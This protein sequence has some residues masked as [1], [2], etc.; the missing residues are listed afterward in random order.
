MADTKPKRHR[1][2]NALLILVLLLVALA[3]SL[4]WRPEMATTALERASM[5]AAGIHSEYTQLG[6]YRIHYLVAGEG[7]PLVLVHGLGGR[8]EEWAPLMHGLAKQHFRVYAIDL[9]GYGRSDKPDVDYSIECEVRILQQ[10]LDSQKLEQADLGGWS[11]GGW[12]VLQLAAE[13]PGRVRRLMVFDSAGVKFTATVDLSLL[14]PKTPAE[15]NGLMKILFAHPPQVSE[16][17]ARS[18]LR[19]TA[20]GDWVVGRALDSMLTGKE[21]LDGKLGAVTV[22][23]LIVWGKQDV[24]TPLSVGQSMQREMPQSRLEVFDD[25]AH[26]TPLECSGRVV[27]EVT[28]FLESDPQEPPGTQEIAAPRE[29]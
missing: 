22:P 3:G 10:F 25:C 19:Q 11:M 21:L 15:L 2:R 24:L 1:L 8:A 9:L 7:R 12:I 4:Y 29:R 26:M 27:P 20:D 18:I 14:R 13:H 17:Y 6:P 5:R 28:R 23:V 16:Y